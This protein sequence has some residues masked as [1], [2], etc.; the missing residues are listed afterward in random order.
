MKRKS[1]SKIGQNIALLFGTLIFCFVV[2]EIGYRLLDPF[3]HF[4][5]SERNDVEHGNL[6]MYDATLGWKGVPGG[7]AQFVTKNNSVWLAN[8]R[9]GFRDIEHDHLT[10]KKPAIV[11]LGDSFTWGHEVEFE[12]MFVNRLRDRFSNYEIFNLAHRGYGTDWGASGFGET[13][14]CGKRNRNWR[15]EEWIHRLPMMSVRSR[16]ARWSAPIELAE[17]S[18]SAGRR[19]DF[20]RSGN[21]KLSAG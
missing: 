10:E 15:T 7:K 16:R 12:E 14:G 17:V 5:H 11:F 18:S 1:L 6:S 9:Q 13:S 4:S 19:G 21:S 3:P 2:I 20:R 8:N